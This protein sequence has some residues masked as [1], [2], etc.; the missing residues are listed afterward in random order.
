MP[1]HVHFLSHIALLRDL[2]EVTRLELATHMT[3]RELGRRAV[4]Q[5]KGVE[6]QALG[7]VL[8]GRL[9]AVDFTLDGREAGLYFV[10]PGEHYG[11]LAVLDGQAAPEYVIALCPSQVLEL[12][13]QAARALLLPIPQVAAAMAIH[14]AARVRQCLAQRTLLALS[15]PAQRLAALL[16]SLAQDRPHIDHTPTHQ[17]LAIMINTTRETVTRTLQ[18]LLARQIVQRDGERLVI[19]QP[20]ALQ[21]MA[22]GAAAEGRP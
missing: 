15:N 4:A 13:A 10:G 9:Q 14:L 5:E 2:P 18:Q 7:F 6:G 20:Q 12:P 11:E 19:L 16:I 17:E 8:T 3:R 1:V 21:A 22:S